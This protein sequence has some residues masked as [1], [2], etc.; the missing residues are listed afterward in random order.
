MAGEDLDVYP[1]LLARGDTS[2]RLAAASAM[3]DFDQLAEDWRRY[4]DQWTRE[5]IDT[6]R[7]GFVA[8]SKAVLSA[9]SRRVQ[10]ENEV[11]YPLALRGGTISLRDASAGL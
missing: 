6:D 2:Q 4:A 5:R 1:L 3:K 10:V 7:A 8:D 11:L 9:L